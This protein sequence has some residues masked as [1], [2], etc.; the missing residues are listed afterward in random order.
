GRRGGLWLLAAGAACCD[1]CGQA[2]DIEIQSSSH[3]A[4]PV[5]GIPTAEGC[6]WQKRTVSVAPAVRLR[7]RRSERSDGR[8]S[9]GG[10]ATIGRTFFDPCP[11]GLD[12]RPT[13]LATRQR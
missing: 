1:H 2:Q 5:R 11:P 13:T 9:F 6:G 8:P 3:H 4:P 7:K 12:V 10:G